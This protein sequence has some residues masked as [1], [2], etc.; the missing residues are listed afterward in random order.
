MKDLSQENRRHDM[1]QPLPDYKS[2]ILP[3]EPPDL[4]SIYHINY[5]LLILLLRN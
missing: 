1:N 2:E 5:P 3:I 4:V